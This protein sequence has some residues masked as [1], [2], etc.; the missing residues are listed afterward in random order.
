MTANIEIRGETRD[1]VLAVPVESVFIRG[2]EEI[3]YV[4]RETP[5]PAEAKDL[6]E[7]TDDEIT[8]DS[9]PWK[10]DP[11]QLWRRWFE[12]RQVVTGIAS[13]TDVEITDGLAQGEE[14]ALAD[15][16]KPQEERS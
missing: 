8:E 12:E 13:T 7:E 11:R 6:T 2:E 4:K 16:S 5:L 3:V 10:D 15:P 14:I 1:N 9:T